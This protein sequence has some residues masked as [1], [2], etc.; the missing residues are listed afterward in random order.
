MAWSVEER[1]QQLRVDLTATSLILELF[2]VRFLARDPD[3]LADLHELAASL[4]TDLD[5]VTLPGAD[6]ATSDHAAQMI[7]EAVQRLL[8]NIRNRLLNEDGSARPWTGGES[9]EIAC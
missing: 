4:K 3:G 8:T 9:F 5:K 2:C 7:S 1:L 6:P